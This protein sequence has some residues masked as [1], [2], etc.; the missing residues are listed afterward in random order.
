VG[1]FRFTV[2][3]KTDYSN[4]FDVGRFLELIVTV[5]L[6]LEVLR[7]TPHQMTSWLFGG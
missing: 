5:S 4:D 3:A 6:F 2:E 7:M 1:I